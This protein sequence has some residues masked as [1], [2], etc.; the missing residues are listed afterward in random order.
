MDRCH[1]IGQTRP[2]LVLRMAT[3]HS[4]EGKMLA[5]AGSKLKLEKLV[6][7]K[8]SVLD[9]GKGGRDDKG[10][11]GGTQGGLT[12]DELVDLLKSKD[13][14]ADLCQSAAIDDEMMTQLLDRSHLE[15]GKSHPYPEAGPGY[16]VVTQQEGTGFLKGVN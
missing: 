9:S 4:V 16:H 7:R 10:S 5:R 1:R 14:A 11:S 13:D 15:A 8:G 12:S 6:I 3:A 2:V